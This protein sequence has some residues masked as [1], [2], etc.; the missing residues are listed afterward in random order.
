MSEAKDRIFQNNSP[1]D[2]AN[3]FLFCALNIGEDMLISG[4]EVSRVEDSIRR[5]CLAY[6]AK[7]VDVFTITSA[8]VVTASSPKFGAVTQTRRITAA[9]YD[10]LK[11]SRLNALSRRICENVLPFEEVEREL[12]EIRI[13]P[14]Q[15]RFFF[16]LF[17]YA[18]IS[19]SFTLFFGGSF[20]DAIVSAGIGMFLK[21]ME[22]A[23]RLLQLPA[24]VA[25]VLWS[26]AG[27]C[28]ALFF[29]SVG[30]GDSAEK[31]SIGNIMLLIPGMQLTNS[32]RDIFN[33]DTLSALLGV[34]NALVLAALIAFGF[35]LP[36]LIWPGGL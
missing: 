18:L 26:F 9:R 35:A 21:C 36:L 6:G 25:A 4:A 23:S 14:P 7:K 8:I 3:E 11:L 16:L 30:F 17:C 2:Y 24:T 27:G 29:V 22:Q 15:Y 20:F 33:G 32:I 34:C 10:L 28:L 19:S 13:L 5:I 31:I 1:T 12:E